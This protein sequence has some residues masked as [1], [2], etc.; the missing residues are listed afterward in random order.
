MAPSSLR[1][2][3]AFI[4]PIKFLVGAA[5]L[6]AGATSAV[7]QPGIAPTS[8]IKPPAV[9]PPAAATVA[10]AT[11]GTMFEV[12][13]ALAPSSGPSSAAVQLSIDAGN[14]AHSDVSVGKNRTAIDVCVLSNV[15]DRVKLSVKYKQSNEALDCDMSSIIIL[16]RGARAEF[17]GDG[18]PQR[19][20]VAVSVK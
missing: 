8:A 20:R 11:P 13:V 17:G 14:C 6:F 7:A 12:V 10:S 4:S 1:G 3:R 9:A 5:I 19:P 2:L 18:G 15:D 16:R